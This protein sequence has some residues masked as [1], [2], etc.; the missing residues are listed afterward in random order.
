MG[1]FKQALINDYDREIPYFLWLSKV[2]DIGIKTYTKM[3]SFFGAPSLVYGASMGKLEAS[4][5]FTKKQLKRIENLRSNYSIIGEY[6]RMLD[7]GISIIPREDERFPERLLDIPSSPIVLFSKGNRLN[8]DGPI[9]SVIGARECSFYGTQ[10]AVRLGELLAQYNITLVSG[11]ARGIDSISQEACV[12]A[13]GNSIAVLGGGVDVLYPRESAKLYD[14]LSRKGT[15]I[16][17]YPPG[18]EPMPAYFAL[19]NRI[20]S[21]LSDVV[22]VVEAKEKSGTMI[23]VDSALEQGRE[24]YAVPGKISDITSKG[25]NQLIKQGA[26]M[27]TDVEEFVMELANIYVKNKAADAGQDIN[28]EETRMDASVYVMSAQMSDYEKRILILLDETSFMGE[29]IAALAGVEPGKMLMTLI[30]FCGKKLLKNMGAGR[31]RISDF[32]MRVRDSI[33]REVS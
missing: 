16:S 17:E 19:R 20:I 8:I 11:M 15:I 33:L 25:C 9:V 4:G 12:S 30:D 23:T 21:G 32:G 13:G 7:L 29:Q 31:F 18:T 22:C 26:G 14:A 5:V 10:V 27:I 3:Q 6:E 28:I 2:G 24:V 1:I